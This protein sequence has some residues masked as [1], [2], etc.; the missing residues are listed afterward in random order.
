MRG[1]CGTV[2]LRAAACTNR[3]VRSEEHPMS[4]RSFVLIGALTA[5]MAVVPI[6]AQTNGKST[7]IPKTP[8]GDPDL[9]GP[10]TSDDTWGVPFERARQFRD[11]CVPYGRR[12]QGPREAGR[13]V[14]AADRASERRPAF[15][16]EAPVGCP[17]QRR[18]SRRCQRGARRGCAKR[19]FGAGS[20][21]VRR[22]CPQSFEANVSD[23]RSAERE[24]PRIDAR[25]QGK[26]GR[27]SRARQRRRKPARP[28]GKTGASMTAA[29]RA[30][31][32]A[33]SF[34]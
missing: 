4:K 24:N 14:E 20:R 29:S 3:A 31:S 30:A 19:R 23:C 22:I 32:P 21:A 17:D 28:R 18:A 1:I 7:A 10:W 34:R 27:H 33:P 9:Q 8:W 12:A 16:R 5:A 13:S 6:V 15:A 25:R 26:A 11:P 2:D